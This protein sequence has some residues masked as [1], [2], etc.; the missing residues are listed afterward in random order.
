M[1]R[2]NPG[3]NGMLDSGDEES[4]DSNYEEA[5]SSATIGGTILQRMLRGN[6]FQGYNS[7]PSSLGMNGTKMGSV[8]SGNVSPVQRLRFRISTVDKTVEDEALLS[9]QSMS[10]KKKTMEDNEKERI[11]EQTYDQFS[12]GEMRAHLA[13][14]TFY[15]LY[16]LHK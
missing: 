15:H 5:G 3:S 10:E 13:T 7:T 12:G 1:I 4:S 16:H 6:S 14:S 2:R 8:L 11:F 9:R